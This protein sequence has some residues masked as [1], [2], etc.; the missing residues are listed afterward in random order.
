VFFFSLS[1][2][3]SL[4][5]FI[6][7][8]DGKFPSTLTLSSVVLNFHFNG[9]VKF[10]LRTQRGNTNTWGGGG[11]DSYPYHPLVVPSTDLVTEAMKFKDIQQIGLQNMA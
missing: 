1:L 3:L 8:I 2:S 7:Y 11:A 6:T 5:L 9:Y 4:S 10:L